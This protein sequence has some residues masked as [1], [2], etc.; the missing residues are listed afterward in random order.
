[1]VTY[2]YLSG[3]TCVSGQTLGSSFTL[4]GHGL[5]TP[6]PKVDTVISCLHLNNS[7]FYYYFVIIS[8]VN[9]IS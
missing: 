6:F 2:H 1:M 5:R 3:I 9:F 8:F 7:P 4:K